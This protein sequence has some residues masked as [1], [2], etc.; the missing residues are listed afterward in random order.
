M[1]TNCCDI[2]KSFSKRAKWNESFVLNHNLQNNELVGKYK[3]YLFELLDFAPEL[4]RKKDASL[5][6]DGFYRIAWSYIRPIGLAKDHFGQISKL[7]LYQYKF[8]SQF[9]FNQHPYINLAR[10]TPNVYY[11]FLYMTKVIFR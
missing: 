2:R 5:T 8:K 7:Q 6:K 3:L 11:D 1:Q 10:N 4:L 9:E